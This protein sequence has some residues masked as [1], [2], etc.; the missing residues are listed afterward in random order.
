M[1]LLTPLRLLC[2]KHL[3][4]DVSWELSYAPD[5]WTTLNARPMRAAT[6][7]AEGAET[8]E[9]DVIIEI[10]KGQRINY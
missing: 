2:F 9:F 8:V 7:P 5:T 6:T 10:P 1:T 4:T 3:P